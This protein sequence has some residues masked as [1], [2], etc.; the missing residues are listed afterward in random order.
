M[1]PQWW[2]VVAAVVVVVEVVLV[3]VVGFGMLVT[4]GVVQLL[5]SVI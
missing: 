3:V 1:R 2:V 5:K 4:A